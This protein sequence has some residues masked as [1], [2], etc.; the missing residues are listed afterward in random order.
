MP[1][2]G[3]AYAIGKITL[4]H[5]NHTKARGHYYHIWFSKEGKDRGEYCHRGFYVKRKRTGEITATDGSKKEK[6]RGD[7]CHRWF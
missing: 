7:Y 2:T 6:D 1:H 5:A 3:M 4:T